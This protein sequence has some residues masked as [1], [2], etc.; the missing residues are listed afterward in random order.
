MAGAIVKRG[1]AEARGEMF[2][3]AFEHFILM[4]LSA[5]AAYSELDYDIHYWRTRQGV[6]VDFI[7]G[8][9]AVAIE[10]KGT[11]HVENKDFRPLHVFVEEYKPGKAILVCNEKEERLIG[12]IRVM[13]WT[14]FL[15][16]LWAGG[17]IGQ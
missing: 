11:S 8:G 3:K 13:P 17:I 15:Q 14:C 9:G 6:E 16:Q 5:H 1:I 4:E 10:V 12:G 7:L 2:G